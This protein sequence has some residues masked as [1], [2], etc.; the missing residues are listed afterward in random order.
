MGMRVL[1]LSD[2]HGNMPALEAIVKDEDWDLMICLGDLV[3]Y[4][5]WPDEVID[6][7][8]ENA[9]YTVMGNHDY[10]LALGGDCGCS[11]EYVELTMYTRR[12][13]MNKISDLYRSYLKS[14]PEKL[15]IDIEGR[16]TNLVHG[17]YKNPLYGFISPD[18]PE[19]VIFEEMQMASGV[20]LFGHS[21]IPMEKDLRDDLKIVNPGSVGFPK[22]NDPRASYVI[23]E[24][25]R[26]H[27]KKI[28]YNVD[29]MINGLRNMDLPDDVKQTLITSIKEGR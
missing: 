4:G 13:T 1:V 24:N 14:L 23:I 29:L 22:G 26:F 28:E 6:Y 20:V 2:I 18:V 15:E 17:S 3:D 10:S 19:E 8:M 21:H 12:A 5:P 27:L 16:H 25:G 7:I 11:E 9:D